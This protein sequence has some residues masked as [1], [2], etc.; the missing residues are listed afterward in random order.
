MAHLGCQWD[1]FWNIECVNLLEAKVLI[2]HHFYI[3]MNI[4]LQKIIKNLIDMKDE[5]K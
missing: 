4:T 2:I 3:K 1:F 5:K